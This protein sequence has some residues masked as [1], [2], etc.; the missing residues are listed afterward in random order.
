MPTNASAPQKKGSMF[1]RN[2]TGL[3]RELTPFHAFNLVFAA[4]LAPVG[5]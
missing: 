3:V 4:I 5:I 1:V 2:A